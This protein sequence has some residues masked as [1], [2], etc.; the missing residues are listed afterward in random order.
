MANA[1]SIE[2]ALSTALLRVPDAAQPPDPAA[3]SATL[4]RLLAGVAS[5]A[6]PPAEAAERIAATPTLAPLLRA[7]AGQQVAAGD[8]RIAFGAGDQPGAI[9]ID[10]SAGEHSITL[11]LPPNFVAGVTP[12]V[13]EQRT[14]NTGGGDYAEGNIDKR[15]GMFYAGGTHYHFSEP[16]PGLP[17]AAQPA[18]ADERAVVKRTLDM[19]RR[20]LMILEEQAAAFGMLYIPAHVQIQLEEKRREVAELEARLQRLAE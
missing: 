14:I 9:V 19:A 8:T 1:S 6:F 17:G 10:D 16:P 18:P 12:V 20:A 3:A 5:G 7:L 2:S 11:R 4:A 15:Q 13:G